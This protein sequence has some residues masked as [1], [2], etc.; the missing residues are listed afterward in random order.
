[1]WLSRLSAGRNS[2][3]ASAE[4]ANQDQPPHP[5]SGCFRWTSLCLPQQICLCGSG[6]R[7]WTSLCAWEPSWNMVSK[8][9]LLLVLSS[10]SPVWINSPLCCLF[11]Y[12]GLLVRFSCVSDLHV[13]LQHRRDCLWSAHNVTAWADYTV[14]MIPVD[15]TALFQAEAGMSVCCAEWGLYIYSC[16]VQ[17]KANMRTKSLNSCDFGSAV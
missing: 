2:A 10:H 4:A 5:P 7:R 8:Q 1:M 17:H 3:Q 16:L 11:F 14:A 9:K 15:V 12:T 13:D 6:S